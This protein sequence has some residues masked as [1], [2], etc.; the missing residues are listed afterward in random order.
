MRQVGVE[1]TVAAAIGKRRRAFSSHRVQIGDQI[2]PAA[3]GQSCGARS[4]SSPAEPV[5]HSGGRRAVDPGEQE[6]TV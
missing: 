4:G 2:R 1:S 6:L 5:A 3:P